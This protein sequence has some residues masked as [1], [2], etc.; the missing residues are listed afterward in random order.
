[1]REPLLAPLASLV[2][3]ILLS[4]VAGLPT[5]SAVAAHLV[6][7][8]FLAFFLWRSWRRLAVSA[9]L[10]T[11]VFAGALVDLI[12]RPP[13]APFIDAGPS[14]SVL[15]EGCVVEPPVL[16]E[17][18]QSFVVEF[19][20]RARARVNLYL[21]E[22]EPPAAL[23]YGRRV[24][25]EGAI[26]TPH[27]FG[28][29]GSFDYVNYLERQWIYWTVS[30]SSADG[31]HELP[32][33]CGSPI[34]AA[35]FSLRTAA[36]NRLDALFAGSLDE[37]A[38]LRAILFGENTRLERVWQ[39]RFRR[40]GTYHTLVISGLHLTI[41]AA[42][43]LF[44]LRFLNLG[45]GW[46]LLL[47]SLVAWT[48]AGVTGW[49]IPV[50]RAAAG[51]SLY[52]VGG[53]FFRRLRLLNILAAI[54][55]VFL[56]ADP[57][58]LFDPSFHMSFLAVAAIGAFAIPLIEKLSQPYVA[59]ARGLNDLDRDLHQQ[60]KTAQLRVELRLLAETLRWISQIP[61]RSSLAAMGLELR[62]FFYFFDLMVISAVIQLALVL[63][64]VVY[65]HR[66]S[67]IGFLANP[68]I[69]FLT[70][71]AVPMGFLAVLTGW[72]WAAGVAGLLVN[73]SMRM[74]TA[75]ASAEPGLRIPDPPLWLVA[76]FLATLAAAAVA[77]RHLRR[78]QI[79]VYGAFVT[80]ATVL[81]WHPFA[82]KVSE[83]VLEVTAID[84]GQAESLFITLPDGE[85]M[86][87][88]GGGIPHFGSGPK[89][90]IEI[91]ED[92]VSPYLWTRSIKHINILAASHGHEDHIGG[93]PALIENF[94]P[95]ELWIGV[96]PGGEPW[97]R[98][99]AAA[100]EY[101]VRIVQ[102]RQG[103]HFELGGAGFTVLA[104]SD[105]YAPD[106]EAQ[107]DDSLVF[108]LTY[109]QRSFLLTGDIEGR[110]ENWLVSENL[111]EPA[112]VLKVPHHGSRTSTS[113]G[114][115]DL[116]RPSVAIVSAGFQNMYGFPH[117]DVLERL[118]RRGV[119]VLRTDLDGL[120]SIRSNGVEL[121]VVGDQN[122]PAWFRRRSAFETGEW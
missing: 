47:T 107:N 10:A 77:L 22:G 30:D 29:P 116:L 27:N 81:L 33:K 95:R 113:A 88:D 80:V 110:I 99:R 74:V 17:G 85:L 19:E 24:D 37:L 115:L 105:E 48:Y 66:I 103:D 43:F 16:F 4:R 57:D 23:H 52:L 20:P 8:P 68:M 65:F 92:V 55:I 69:V 118:E 14:E 1:V 94:R 79:A 46:A 101:G 38:M 67:V 49:N 3:G 61:E 50:V 32:G 102:F 106:E 53:Y 114:L 58:Q 87:V 12:H 44:V 21:D 26:R 45:A 75:F 28:N 78:M 119:Q 51:L 109:G 84:V 60:P 73:A 72:G 7:V 120:V 121:E 56:I 122:E 41:L 83:G 82:P 31:V 117:P 40:T 34:P 108:R 71:L 59:A 63:P 64:M 6:L 5:A 54:A 13:P 39:D 18:R 35:I 15:I 42:C 36:L 93:L 97:E 11:L 104:P 2:G 9:C 111:L 90:R 91:G 62:V 98:L 100:N 86:M 76:L 25:L 112:D 96:M 70:I 89:P